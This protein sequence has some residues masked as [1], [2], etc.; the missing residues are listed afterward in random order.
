[1]RILKGNEIKTDLNVTVQSTRTGHEIFSHFVK[2]YHCDTS[3]NA[4]PGRR[5]NKNKT[6]AIFRGE[7]ARGRAKTY[8]FSRDLFASFHRRVDLPKTTGPR[9]RGGTV[10]SVYDGK[11]CR[12]RRHRRRARFLH[13]Y[14]YKLTYGTACERSWCVV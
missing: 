4:K 1:M 5:S 8:I 11:S 12:R 3:K 9:A 14:L 13:F 10:E 2:T 7:S 6:R